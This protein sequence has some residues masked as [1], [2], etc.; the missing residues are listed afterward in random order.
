[1]SFIVKDGK[2]T[3]IKWAIDSTHRGLVRAIAETDIANVSRDNGL[4]FSMGTSVF[5]ITSTQGLVYWFYNGTQDKEF[6]LDGGTLNWNGGDTNHNRALEVELQAG[7]TAPTTGTAA[8]NISNVNTASGNSATGLGFSAYQWDGT[9]GTG[10]TGHS[11]GITLGTLIQTS[12]PWQF[13]F[14]GSVIVAP[15]VTLGLFAKGEETGKCSFIVSG[16][17]KTQGEA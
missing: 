2:G 14:E 4:S 6:I 15:G 5:P 7:T 12:S 1:M 17:V 16:Y 11:A 3:G 9:T 10:I 8:I 13:E